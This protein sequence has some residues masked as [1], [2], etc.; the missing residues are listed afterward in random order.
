MLTCLKNMPKNCG[1]ANDA[2]DAEWQ[3]PHMS[4]IPF[5]VLD[6]E[7][8]TDIEAANMT[9]KELLF[10]EEVS[11]FAPAVCILC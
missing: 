9:D 6:L 3:V 8:T 1:H 7:T 2:N 4:Q 10:Q 5:M 11:L